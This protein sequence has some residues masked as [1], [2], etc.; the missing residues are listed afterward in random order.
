MLC[1]CRV[2]GHNERGGGGG[3][4]RRRR[5]RWRR[6]GR[7]GGPQTVTIPQP[8]AHSSLSAGAL[9]GSRQFVATLLCTPVAI[10]IPQQ[11]PSG[12]RCGTPHG[13]HAATRT[14]SSPQFLFSRL[15]IPIPLPGSLPLHPCSH[16]KPPVPSICSRESIPPQCWRACHSSAAAARLLH[17]PGVRARGH[18]RP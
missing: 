8:T 18:V 10:T 12:L 17:C 1:P 7:D 14:G 9:T 16:G 15:S 5:R 11:A 3:G 13:S 4:R 6:R 2:Q